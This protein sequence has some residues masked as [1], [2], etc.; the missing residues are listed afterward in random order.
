MNQIGDSDVRVD[1]HSIDGHDDI[2]VTVSGR[3][4]K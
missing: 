2:R 1:W 4:R 3:R